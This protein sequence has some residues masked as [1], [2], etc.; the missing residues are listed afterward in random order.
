MRKFFKSLIKIF[1]YMAGGLV[2]LLAIA[3][4]LFRLFL[5]R[6]PEYQDDIKE[7]ASAAIGLSAEFSGMDA[8]WGLSGPE[9]EFFDAELISL[10]NQARIVAADEVSVGVGLMRLLVE[11]KPMVDR[12]AVRDTTLEVRQQADGQWWIQGRPTNE[13]M[14][15]RPGGTGNGVGGP[16]KV[17]G[18]NI[19]VLFLRPGDERPREFQISNF[20]FRA[21]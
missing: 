7:W 4:G 17:V 5:P 20:L 15:K 2:I 14:P 18:E 19:Q 6:L 3:V 9:I 16:N 13:L 1:A 10:D 8:R 12:V 11:G 21:V